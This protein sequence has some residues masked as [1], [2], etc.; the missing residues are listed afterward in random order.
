MRFSMVNDLFDKKYN[1]F[2]KALYGT[3]QARL[4]IF[5]DIYIASSPSVFL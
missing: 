1:F 4:Y 5:V 2:S 3:A